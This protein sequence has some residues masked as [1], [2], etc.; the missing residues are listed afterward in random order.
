MSSGINVLKN[1]GIETA[2]SVLSQLGKKDLKTILTEEG[3]KII[4]NFSDKAV[5]KIKNLNGGTENKQI[6]SGKMPIGLSPLQLQRLVGSS[7]KKNALKSTKSTSKR[8]FTHNRKIGT[9]IRKLSKG[10]R[11]I[12]KGRKRTK[13]QTGQGKSKRKRKSTKRTRGN[14]KNI[15][16]L[17]IFN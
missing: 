11:Q 15:R 14:K 5:D 17:D 9:S 7:V 6:G 12:G 3:E 8:Q 2:G 16:T 10:N 4:R 13:R 1:Q